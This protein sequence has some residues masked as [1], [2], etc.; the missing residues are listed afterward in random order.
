MLTSNVETPYL[1]WDNSTRSQLMDFLQTNC[2]SHV[3]T[4][5]SDP[6]YGSK[7]SFGAHEDHLVVGGVF[8][9]VYNEQPMYP[10]EVSGFS[11]YYFFFFLRDF[12]FKKT[13]FEKLQY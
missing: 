10:I 5:Q 7:F 1:V 6:D 4:G 9:K 2:D 8:I 13:L 12:I 3:K 11:S